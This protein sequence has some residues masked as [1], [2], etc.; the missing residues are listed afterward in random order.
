MKKDKRLQTFANQS[1]SEF[2]NED[3]LNELKTINKASM[4]LKQKKRNK[5]KVIFGTSI[6]TV[7]VAMVTIFSLIF[8]P[9]FNNPKVEKNYNVGN[10][11]TVES[12]LNS[13]NLELSQFVFVLDSEVSIFKVEDKYYDETLYYYFNITYD[14]GDVLDVIVI[15]NE[16]YEFSFDHSYDNNVDMGV[17]SMAYTEKYEMLD[18]DMFYVETFG[19]IENYKEK[20]YL[21]YSGIVFEEKSSFVEKITQIIEIKE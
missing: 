17:F 16:E 10:Q 6:A 18:S 4:D 1:L 15:T 9:F 3:I 12:E 20:I 19:A 2:H 13:L 7:A 21:S 5:R 8:V 11:V 14:S